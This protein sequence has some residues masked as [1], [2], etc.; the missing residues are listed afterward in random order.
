LKYT[1]GHRLTKGTIQ[2]LPNS[3]IDDAEIV[4][5]DGSISKLVHL[6]VT[7]SGSRPEICTKVK[8]I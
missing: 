4:G 5:D 6:L 3:Q 2:S 8:V 1:A 7:M